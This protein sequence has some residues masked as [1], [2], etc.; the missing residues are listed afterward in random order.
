MPGRCIGL[1]R[2]GAIDTKGLCSAHCADCL[3]SRI[4][5]LQSSANHSH[6]NCCAVLLSWSNIYLCRADALD[7][8]LRGHGLHRACRALHNKSHM[9]SRLQRRSPSLNGTGWT[10]AGATHRSFSHWD[11]AAHALSSQIPKASARHVFVLD[12]D[13]RH[14]TTSQGGGGL[15]VC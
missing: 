10:G 11:C 14:S 6:P 15:V 3:C 9:S 1:R 8:G 4:S 7:C 5:R 12:H 2:E 13:S